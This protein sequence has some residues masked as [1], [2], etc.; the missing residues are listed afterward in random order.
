MVLVFVC[1]IL[2]A[3]KDGDILF[4]EEVEMWIHSHVVI[5]A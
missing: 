5:H 4:H 3:L 1:W 2:K